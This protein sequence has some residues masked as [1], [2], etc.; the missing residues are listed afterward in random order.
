MRFSSILA[1][2]MEP[3]VG[4]YVCVGGSGS[5]SFFAC[6]FGVVLD[7]FQ[8]GPRR[9]KGCPQ[10]AHIAVRPLPKQHN[11]NIRPSHNSSYHQGVGRH[12]RSVSQ[13]QQRTPKSLIRIRRAGPQSP[14]NIKQGA[15]RSI[16]DITRGPKQPYE[17]YKRGLT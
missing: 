12:S 14:V 4:R 3:Q 2:Q 1:S 5:S 15:L 6:Y 8:E 10:S 9:F 17:C 16:V 7:R 11:P 13:Y